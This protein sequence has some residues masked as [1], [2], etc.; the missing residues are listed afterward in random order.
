MLIGL[1]GTYCAGKNHISSILEERGLPVLDVDKL[2]Y[3]ALETEKEAVFDRFGRDIQREDGSVDRR[4]LGQRVFGKPE[5]LTAL[6]NIVHPPV[7]RMTDDWIAA[8][9]SKELP[10]QKRVCII[11][12]AL[13]HR[14]SA[15]KKLDCIILVTAPLVTRL[16]RAR[17][18]DNLSWASVFKRFASQKHFNSQY[19]SLNAEI[20]RVENPGICGLSNA[21]THSAAM[22]NRK[23]LE[24]RINRIL[25][26]IN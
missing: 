7:N 13:L 4:L 8:H 11:N 9:L 16:L 26:G 2:G 23:K 14:S 25:E 3:Q 22:K 18:R 10:A 19:L 15:F 12:A 5:E 21:S 20:Y 1:T 17:K 24:Y 6:E